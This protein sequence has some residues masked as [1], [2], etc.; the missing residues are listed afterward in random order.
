[1][2][3]R[4]DEMVREEMGESSEQVRSEEEEDKD[5]SGQMGHRYPKS[6][7]DRQCRERE[8]MRE[9]EGQTERERVWIRERESYQQNDDQ[10]DQINTVEYSDVIMQ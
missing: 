7:R 5:D 1:M 3:E 2:M 10:R 4:N 6:G 9:R 8:R